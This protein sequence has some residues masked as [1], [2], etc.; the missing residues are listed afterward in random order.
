VRAVGLVREFVRR[1]A[2]GTLNV[3]GP[4]ASGV[5]EAYAYTYAL[6]R[7]VLERERAD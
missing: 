3:A 4:R 1:H 2:V 6:V 7:G 5:P